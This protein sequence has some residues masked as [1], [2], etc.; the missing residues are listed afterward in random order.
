METEWTHQLSRVGECV[1]L[2]PA[3]GS[4]EE[5][6]RNPR[7]DPERLG[8]AVRAARERTIFKPENEQIMPTDRRASAWDPL[9]P[10]GGVGEDEGEP[11][12]RREPAVAS[13]P[14]EGLGEEEK[15]L[16]PRPRGRLS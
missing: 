16:D 4:G 9:L 15:L 3:T 1:P 12:R 7:I 8:G 14:E 11:R 6:D 13:D 2:P 5:R 10:G